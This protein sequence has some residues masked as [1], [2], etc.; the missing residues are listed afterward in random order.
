MERPVTLRSRTQALLDLVEQERAAQCGA[1]LDEARSQAAVLQARTRA[2]S[3]AAVHQALAEERSRTRAA[4]AAAQAEL[5]T[6]QR[7]HAQRRVEALLALGWRRLPEALRTRWDDATSRSQWTE[8]ALAL[9]RALLPHTGWVI[10][11]GD[12]WPEPERD[13]LAAR[14]DPAPRF[15]LDA[16]IDAGLRIAAGGNVVDATLAGLLADRDEIGARLVGLLETHLEPLA[17]QAGP[18]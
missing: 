13:A 18:P 6:R 3:R 12:G 2:E 15:T 8:H 1:I 17:M 14:L 16:R 11:H 9:A 5:H 10:A 7:L 4:I